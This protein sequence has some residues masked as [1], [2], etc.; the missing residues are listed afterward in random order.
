MIE[1][2]MLRSERSERSYTT[3]PCSP[4]MVVRENPAFAISDA[5]RS[6]SIWQISV[7]DADLE[8]LY[9]SALLD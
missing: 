4:L 3:M 8:V 5:K 2:L 7:A 1:T 6:K 9:G